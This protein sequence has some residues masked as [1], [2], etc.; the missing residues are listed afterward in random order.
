MTPTEPRD[1]AAAEPLAVEAATTSEPM[2]GRMMWVMMAGCCV[3]I[4]LALIF[5]FASAG[6]LA[7]AS[8]WLIGIGVVLAVLL[9]LARRRPSRSSDNAG[10]PRT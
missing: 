6:S 5:G 7:G 8:P 4:P 1:H 10:K 2:D 9:L 3:V